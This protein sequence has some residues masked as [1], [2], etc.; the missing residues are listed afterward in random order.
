MSEGLAPRRRARVRSGLR[1]FPPKARLRLEGLWLR[2]LFGVTKNYSWADVEGFRMFG[3]RRHRRY[4]SRL[5]RGRVEPFTVRLFRD[6]VKPGMHV[7]DAGAYLGYYTL[8]ALRKM[9]SHGSVYAFECNPENYRFLL[10]N[11]WANG[12][13]RGA[14]VSEAAVTDRA[15]DVSLDVRSWDLS[16]GSIHHETGSHERMRVPA[17]SLDEALDGRPIDVMKMDIEGGELRALDGMTHIIS[18]SPQLVM[19]VECNPGALALSGASAEDLLD[20]LDTLG[21]E[22]SEIDER[23]QT[24][25]PVGAMLRAPPNLEDTS[26]FVNLHCRKKRSHS[27]ERP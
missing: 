11:I 13:R 23:E 14:V 24:L 6:A 22:V 3:S 5:A 18:I 9:N 7:V 16:Q 15:G 26:F 21:F 17:T 25:R 20:R 12:Y 1:T 4:L 10:H 27:L 2:V 19:F 8:V